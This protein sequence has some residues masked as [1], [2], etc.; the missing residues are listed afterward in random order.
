[1]S[2][3]QAKARTAETYLAGLGASGA[4][5]GGAIVSFVILVGIVTFNAWPDAAGLFTFSGGQAEVGLETSAGTGAERTASLP[6]LITSTGGPAGPTS[7]R[8][9]E[10]GGPGATDLP[11]EGTGTA[12]VPGGQDTPGT[13]PGSVGGGGNLLSNAGNMVER[14]TATLGDALN[15]T[16][17]TN[18]GDVVTGLGKTLNGTL[19]GLTGSN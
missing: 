4:L 11:D 2:V 9:G 17:G 8:A 16:T 7:G 3:F 19:Q 6:T 12:P 10:N 15:Q 1:M 18:V 5:V 14:D 13:E